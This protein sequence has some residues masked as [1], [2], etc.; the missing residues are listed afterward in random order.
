[1]N[2]ST[3][4][5]SLP[6]ILIAVLLALPATS[7]AVDP[8]DRVELTGIWEGDIKISGTSLGFVVEFRPS[9]TVEWTGNIDIAVQG[10]EDVPLSNIVVDGGKVHFDMP[11]VPG[12]PYFEGSLS[13]DGRVISGDFHQGDSEWPFAMQRRNEVSIQAEQT[14]L[15]KKLER[16]RVFV[17]SIMPEWKVPGAA[18]G[19]V[20]NGHVVMAEGFGL[21]NRADSLPVTRYTLFAIGSA[22]KAFTTA[23]MATLVADGHLDWDET[24]RAYLP[25]FRMYDQFA[26]ERMTL[27]DLVIH[28][29]GLPRHDAMW[30]N[31]SATRAELFGRLQ[32]LRPN[33][34][35]R[36]TFQYQNLMYMTAGYLLGQV[37]R[38]QWEDVV[39]ERLLDPLQMAR[40]NF[41][42]T[43]MSK[44]PDHA[45]P[46]RRHEDTVRLIDYRDI[47]TMGPAGSIN[48][49]IVEMNRWINFHLS[50]GKNGDGEQVLPG[51]LIEEMHT[52]QMAISRPE[53]YTEA[54]YTSY[55]LGWFVEAY[56]GHRRVHHGGNIDG[57]SALVSLYPDDDLGL[58][59][60]T[61]LD[62]APLPGI[63]C[64][65]I[66]DIFLGLEPVDY[67]GRSMARF[68]AG[69][70]V[71]EDAKKAQEE[72]DRVDD[73]KPSHKLRHYAGEY[74]NPGYGVMT[75][76]WEDKKLYAEYNNLRAELE[77]W[78]YDVFMASFPELDDQ[79]IR[80]NFLT[81]PS[82]EIDEVA[83]PFE[84]AVDDIVFS[85]QPD[86]RL[87]D[88]RFLSQLTGRYSL[89]DQTAEF[90]LKGTR[91][92]LILPGQPTY[93]LE[94][95][96]ESRFSI[97]GLNGFFVEFV[98]GD[99][100]EP[101][102][103]E[104]LFVQPNGVFKAEPVEESQ[105]DQDQN[106]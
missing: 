44:S 72:L 8:P 14:T 64:H 29:S 41:S 59:I 62:G 10:A 60:L 23:T 66:A 54:L 28:R 78:H 83:V 26:T 85:R 50:G 88:P 77:H 19:I 27:R 69:E 79:R 68:E 36:T 35:F 47:S 6:V 89:A 15:H 99:K 4:Y 46:Y 98:L 12:A 38:G 93:E 30:Y 67:H 74:G 82:G 86:R 33:E 102:V 61:N 73:T 100:D 9:D 5:L 94:P 92:V 81:N 32:Y 43:Q 37:T 48:S 7:F 51:V 11:G 103:R 101:T 65:R 49:C 39:R 76:T 96:R 105:T 24:V 87:S 25:R 106:E 56:R 90:Q 20:H 58:V 34:D 75:I 71:V 42:V 16:I 97:K 17:D 91:L 53:Q 22:T 13:E 63:V 21:R 31:S 84:P 52:P 3:R 55:G 2:L 1:M 18:I 40:T 104:V 45:L 95:V 57:F 70:E 80:F